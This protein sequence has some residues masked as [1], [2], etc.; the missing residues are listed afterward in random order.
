MMTDEHKEL[1][2]DEEEEPDKDSDNDDEDTDENF[3]GFAFLQKD[4]M[5]SL[6]DKPGIPASWILLNRKQWY[7]CSLTRN[8]LLISG[9]QNG[10]SC[11]IAI[12]ERQLLLRKVT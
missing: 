2:D 3:E 4:V 1:D 8:C 7:T 5:C 12:Q 9:T 10:L 11:Y 6:Q